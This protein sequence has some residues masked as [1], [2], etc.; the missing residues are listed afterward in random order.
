MHVHCGDVR[1]FDH[2]RRE[3]HVIAVDHAELLAVG[4]VAG[5]EGAGVDVEQQ[6]VGQGL[7][8]FLGVEGGQVN[9]GRSEGFVGGCKDRVGTFALQCF[10]QLG[11]N[12]GGH[13]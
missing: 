13:E 5:S 2:A 4:D 11:L 10:D 1:T 9:A 6:D 12:Q 3:H 7:L 8:A